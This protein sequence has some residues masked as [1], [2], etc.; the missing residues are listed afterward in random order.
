MDSLHCRADDFLGR[1]ITIYTWPPCPVSVKFSV[2]SSCNVNWQWNFKWIIVLI[3]FK[4][5]TL[6]RVKPSTTAYHLLNYLTLQY[7]T[8]QYPDQDAYHYPYPEDFNADTLF[9]AS[10]NRICLFLPYFKQCLHNIAI[11]HMNIHMKI[12]QLL[13]KMWQVNFFYH[14]YVSHVKNRMYKWPTMY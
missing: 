10:V 9:H 13:F 11:I 1:C 2:F 5:R 3:I 14:I 4:S 12:Q 7:S 6:S 8:F